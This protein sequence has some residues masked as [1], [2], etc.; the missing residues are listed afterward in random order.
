MCDKSLTSCFSAGLDRL[1]EITIQ[2][3]NDLSEKFADRKGEAFNPHDDLGNWAAK[4][5]STLVTG[6]II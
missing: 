3:I 5:M 6:L 2:A 1:E 4:I